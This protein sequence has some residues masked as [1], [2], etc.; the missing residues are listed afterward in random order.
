MMTYQ[1]LRGKRLWLLLFLSAFAL[2]GSYQLFQNKS[3]GFGSSRITSDFS[4][5]PEWAIDEPQDLKP[6]RSILDQKFKFLA[7]GSQSYAFVSEDGKYVVKFFIMKHLIPRLTDF[8]H[9]EKV[10]YRKQNLFSIFRAHKL[11]YSEL[12]QDTGLIYIHLNKSNHLKTRLKVVD[13]LGRTHHIDLDQTEFVV[14]EK[15]ELIFTHLKKLLDQGDKAKVQ[16]CIQATLDLVK[17]RMDKGISDHDKAVKHNYG[18]IGD[19]AIH[20]DIGRIEKISKP[21][22]YNRITERINTWLQE[23]DTS[24]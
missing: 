9:P 6:L 23:N 20:L 8:W 21:K 4:Y 5:H 19:R 24:T 15:A 1:I 17:H 10:E 14:Q 18:F 11:A 16:K 3:L 13:R 2:W 22:E 12:K 7:V